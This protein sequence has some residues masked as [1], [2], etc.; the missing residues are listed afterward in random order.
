M[1]CI[2]C[3]EIADEVGSHL[4]PASLIKNCVGRHYNE[5]SY[6]IDEKYPKIDVFFG[7]DNLKNRSTEI[8]QNH[9]KRDNILCKVCEKKLANLESKFAAE[10]LNKYRENKFSGNFTSSISN[11]K[12]EVLEP[13][14]IS[15]L[16]IQVYF[17]S[18]ILRFCSTYKFENND[19]YIQEKDLIKI[20]LF[21][22]NYFFDQ[23]SYENNEIENFK[24]AI[25]FNKYSTKSSF[26]CTSDVLKNPYIFYFCEAIIILYVCENFNKNIAILEDCLNTINDQF[27][28]IIV[29]PQLIFDKFNSLISFYL[30]NKFLTNGIKLI[31]E[32]NQK[33]F[34]ENKIEVK[35]L[36][37]K[38]KKSGNLNQITEIFEELIIKY[39]RKLN[40]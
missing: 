13:N 27:T 33:S 7:R 40:E 25:I 18:I 20:K 12:L 23:N 24:I 21:L 8:K 26:I 1:N 5:E 38:Y 34:E 2:I 37:E 30:A 29:G 35:E 4:I 19:S 17:Y 16:E 22:K 10:F 3:D 39:T 9:Y 36:I 32:L 31:S 28:K 15:N 6:C 11:S 14:K